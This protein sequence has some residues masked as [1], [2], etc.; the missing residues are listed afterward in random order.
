M[1]VAFSYFNSG[2]FGC[3]SVSGGCFGSGG[4]GFFLGA[5]GEQ[6]EHHAKSQDQ[7]ENLLH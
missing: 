5:A 3:G 4:S 2:S 7:S 6:C 1:S